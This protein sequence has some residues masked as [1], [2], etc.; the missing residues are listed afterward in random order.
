MKEQYYQSYDKAD[1]VR[2][3]APAKTKGRKGTQEAICMFFAGCSED[4]SYA[5]M[6]M[7]EKTKLGW[8]ESDVILSFIL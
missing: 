3:E 6:N 7:S 8:Y 1:S 4:L 5:S 2:G